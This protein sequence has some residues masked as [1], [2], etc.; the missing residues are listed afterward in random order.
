MQVISK[1][2]QCQYQKHSSKLIL[3]ITYKVAVQIIEK[4][5]LQT[6]KCRLES[7]GVSCKLNNRWFAIK[8]Q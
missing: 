6:V 4:D 5:A 1:T 7:G 3:K 8:Q 2:F